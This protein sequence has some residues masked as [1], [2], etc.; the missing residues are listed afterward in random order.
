MLSVEIVPRSPYSKESLS[1][2][3]SLLVYVKPGMLLPPQSSLDPGL[4]TLTRSGESF[5]PLTNIYQAF[6][7]CWALC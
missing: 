4:F 3:P 2:F 1:K 7:T 6:T 5:I